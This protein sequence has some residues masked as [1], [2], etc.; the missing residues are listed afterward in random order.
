LVAG[1]SVLFFV[2][3]AIFLIARTVRRSRNQRVQWIQLQKGASDSRN[4]NSDS[5][6]I[7][8]AFDGASP[9]PKYGIMSSERLI[10][11]KFSQ[12]CT[13]AFDVHWKMTIH[14][15]WGRDLLNAMLLQRAML[16]PYLLL[17]CLRS[18]V[19]MRTCAHVKT[20]R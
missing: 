9:S 4:S 8:F 1:V 11:A 17:N 19:R 2:A 5:M 20:W 18:D 16:G 15:R 3:V 6:C 13:P 14:A 10:C 7:K 12:Q